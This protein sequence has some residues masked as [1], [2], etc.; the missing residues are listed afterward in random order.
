[1][2]GAGEDNEPPVGAQI[3]KETG[4]LK[5]LTDFTNFFLLV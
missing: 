5:K 2:A 1:M 3:F 4:T